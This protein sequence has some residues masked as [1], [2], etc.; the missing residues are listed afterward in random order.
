MSMDEMSDDEIRVRVLDTIGAIAPG[1]DVSAL[2]PDQPLRK[3]IELDSMDWLNLIDGLHER[4][5]REIP[6]T[7]YASLSTLDSITDWFV[8]HPPGV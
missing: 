4:L 8:K 2:R 3:Q 5:G 7:D 1:T 6:E